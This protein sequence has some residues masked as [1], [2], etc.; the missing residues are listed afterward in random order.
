MDYT[1]LIAQQP[2]VIDN[3]CCVLEY[4]VGVVLFG[5]TGVCVCVCGRGLRARAS[6]RPASRVN[7]RQNASFPTSQSSQSVGQMGLA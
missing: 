3:V 7:R 4:S 5:L 1:D 2:V 6:S